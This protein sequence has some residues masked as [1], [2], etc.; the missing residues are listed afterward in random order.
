MPETIIIGAG[1]TGLA[2]AHFLKTPYII[3]EKEDTPGGLCRSIIKDGF[4]FDYSGHFIHLRN[5]KIKNKVFKLLE[6]N[7]LKI[8]RSAWIYTN[9]R[10]IPYPFQ[11][12]LGS[13]PDNVKR[14]CLNGFLNRSKGLYKGEKDSFNNWSLSTFGPGI[15]KHFMKPYNEKLWTVSGNKLTADWVAPFVPM[16][17]IQEVKNSVLGKQKKK[18][19]YNVSFFYPKKGGCQTLVDSFSNELNDINLKT[20]ASKINIK[21]KYI[22]TSTGK[23]IY[24]DNLISTQP[25]TT[26]IDQINVLPSNIRVAGRKLKCNSVTCLNIGV[27][28]N[29]KNDY[30]DGK[31]WIYFPDKKYP[32]YRVGI[33]SNI[34]PDSAPKGYM[35]FYVE[36]SRKQNEAVNKKELFSKVAA[37][38]IE[39]GMI[40]KRSDIKVVNWLDIPYAYV[41]YDKY[42]NEALNTIQKFLAKNKIYSIGRYGAWKYSFIE[43]SILDAKNLVDKIER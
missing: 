15:T 13:L 21:D 34:I 30:V 3:I 41:I 38:L 37:G 19:G 33:Y 2:C 25:I 11:A 27:K 16:P 36:V 20:A 22:E 1:I 6:N 12:N 10:I 39:A 17:T 23:K 43:E 24:Y 4:T 29:I 31:H 9:R 14:D 32:F 40:S 35:S 26:L 5:S 28:A 18:Y 8:N 42:R 7:V